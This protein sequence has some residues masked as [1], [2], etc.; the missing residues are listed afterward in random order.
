MSISLADVSSGSPGSVYTLSPQH[1]N[2]CTS[3]TSAS[4]STLKPDAARKRCAHAIINEKRLWFVAKCVCVWVCVFQS[5]GPGLQEKLHL[6]HHDN[7]LVTT[8]RHHPSPN[9]LSAVCVHIWMLWTFC[10]C[11]CVCMGVSQKGRPL[12]NIPAGNA[13]SSKWWPRP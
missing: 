4:F 1:T 13:W 3:T 8:G 6:Y 5:E 7:S 11:V 12:G 2:G 10:M 9:P